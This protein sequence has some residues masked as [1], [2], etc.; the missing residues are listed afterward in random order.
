M[1]IRRHWPGSRLTSH[2]TNFL[3]TTRGNTVSACATPS[4]RASSASSTA[5]LSYMRTSQPDL[6][7]QL[8]VRTPPVDTL[9][10][11]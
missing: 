5:S 6:A 10:E 2:Y 4:E 3:D 7:V 8:F 11:T 9:F 1:V